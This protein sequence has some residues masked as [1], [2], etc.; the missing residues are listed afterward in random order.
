MNMLVAI[1]IGGAVGALGRHFVNV[2]MGSLLGTG[3]PWG[4]VTVNIVGSFLMGVLIHM[5]AVSWNV[6]PEMRALL[7][8]GA[9]GAFTTFSTFSLDV[10]TMYER[11]AL[12]LVGVY[13]VVSV[14]ASIGALLVGLRLA[15]VVA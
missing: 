2:A 6:S 1:A 9:L 3:F 11:D 10:V 14:V 12:L 8:V 15:R 13:V 4:T 5:L 7:T